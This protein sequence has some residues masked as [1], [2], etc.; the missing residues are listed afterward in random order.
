[1]EP[2]SAA[3]RPGGGEA[4]PT[5][6]T[7]GASWTQR[8]PA[9][10]PACRS[11]LLLELVACASAC[12]A[13]DPRYKQHMEPPRSNRAA[14]AAMTARTAKFKIG[15]D[16]PPPDLSLPGRDLRRRSGV[17]QHRGMVPGHSGASAPV[18]GPPFYHLYAD[19]AEGSNE[20]YVSE[21][22]LRPTPRTARSA[23]RGCARISAASSTVLPAEDHERTPGAARARAPRG[24]T[25]PRAQAA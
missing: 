15:P 12:V 20:A 7:A 3:C 24:A 21:Q 19:N 5:R 14:P 22:N 18:E 6:G 25:S 10:L 8:A 13:R 17:R 1:L 16:R 11:S 9:L 4:E 23:I 2:G